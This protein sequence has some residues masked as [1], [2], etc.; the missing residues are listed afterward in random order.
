[1]YKNKYRPTTS[2]TVNE[3]VQGESIE[4]KIERLMTNGDENTDSKELIFTRAE[5]GV[6]PAFDIR[7]DWWDQAYEETTIMAEKNNEL[8]AKRLE[9]R[10]EILKAKAEEEKF[11]REHAKESLKNKG[12]TGAEGG[13][14]EV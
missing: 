3:S 9:K 8:D 2:L 6:I 10:K 11:L 13:Q 1:M 7:H 12:K 14:P 5:D 4:T